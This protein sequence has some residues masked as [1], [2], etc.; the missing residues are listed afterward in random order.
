MA[1]NEFYKIDKLL[2]YKPKAQARTHIQDSD[3][4]IHLS[5]TKEAS[6]LESTASF[7]AILSRYMGE[8]HQV[9][10]SSLDQINDREAIKKAMD[11]VESSYATMMQIRKELELAYNNF[12]RMQT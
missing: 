12:I 2:P 5:Q 4:Q 8:A 10:E 9:K 7:K 11:D 3:L 1:E 6:S